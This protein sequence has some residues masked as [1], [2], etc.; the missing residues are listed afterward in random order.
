MAIAW[1]LSILAALVIGYLYRDV[2]DRLKDIYDLLK[3]KKDKKPQVEKPT[4]NL[5]DPLDIEAEAK[6]Q[7]EQTLKRM[8]PDYDEDN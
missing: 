4:S 6:Y 5:I 3:E 2:R 8:N 7:Y 1:V